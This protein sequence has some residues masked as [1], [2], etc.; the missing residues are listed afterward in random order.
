MELKKERSNNEK[1]RTSSSFVPNGQHPWNLKTARRKRTGCLFNCA[2]DDG[3][4]ER[5]PLYMLQEPVQELSPVAFA[6]TYVSK[7]FFEVQMA[8]SSSRVFS[9]K[10][11]CLDQN[12][13]ELSSS[14]N[15]SDCILACTSKKFFCL[16][17]WNPR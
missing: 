14:A 8:T 12:S 1:R 5:L 2:T 4:S 9:T 3:T 7:S 17:Q 16:T 10:R 6:I 13:L 15:S 11:E